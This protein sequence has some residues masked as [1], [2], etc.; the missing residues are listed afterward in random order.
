MKTVL[1]FVVTLGAFFQFGCA[2]GPKKESA[3]RNMDE[4]R[5]D[6]RQQTEFARS[7]PTATP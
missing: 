6:Y 7:L 5:K 2:G 1:L 3:M 4:E